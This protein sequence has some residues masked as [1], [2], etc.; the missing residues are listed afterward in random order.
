M[1]SK[2]NIARYD[3]AIHHPSYTKNRLAFAQRRITISEAHFGGCP[4]N[5][6]KK[7]RKKK[8]EAYCDTLQRVLTRHWSEGQG[9]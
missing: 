3:T 4:K 5:K 1:M 8:W 6:K 2:F 7:K 9:T